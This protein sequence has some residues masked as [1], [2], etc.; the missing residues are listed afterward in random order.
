MTMTT[1]KTESSRKLDLKSMDDAPEGSR[2]LLE[3]AE[4]NFG[5]VPNLYRVFADNPAALASY[6]AIGDALAEHGTLSAT[7]QQLVMLTISRTNECHYCVAAHTTVGEQVGLSK[8]AI[9]AIREDRSLDDPKLEALRRLAK[10]VVNERGWLSEDS[11]REF[12]DAGYTRPQ[13][14]EVIT[15][16]AM[17]TLS[18]YTNHLA[19]TP[20]DQAFEG[21]RWKKSG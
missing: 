10:S 5:F 17:K 6:V 14:L 21:S 4:K 19:Q 18:N 15:I 11:V 20:L 13:L 7:E 2:P 16:T 12:L 1:T 8:G 9:E 3:R